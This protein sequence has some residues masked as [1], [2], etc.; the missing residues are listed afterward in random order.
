MN[1]TTATVA[2]T[3]TF[4]VGTASAVGT[5]VLSHDFPYRTCSV[6]G[7]PIRYYDLSDDDYQ[8]RHRACGP[9]ADTAAD[10][11]PEDDLPDPHPTIT[12]ESL[13]ACL[14]EARDWIRDCQWADLDTDD[15]DDLD[16]DQVIAGVRRHYVGGWDS[17]LRDS[18]RLGDVEVAR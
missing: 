9:S 6:C 16:D 1:A 10:L 8:P 18:G 17:F 12:A 13:A 15:V 5:A 2:T 4:A 7:F 11:P 14:A 3:D